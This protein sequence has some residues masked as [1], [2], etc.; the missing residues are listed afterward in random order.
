MRQA[1]T[2]QDKVFIYTTQRKKDIKKE[3]ATYLRYKPHRI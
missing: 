2:S 3:N 1:E